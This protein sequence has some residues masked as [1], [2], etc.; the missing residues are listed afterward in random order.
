MSLDNDSRIIGVQLGE[1]FIRVFN[2]P[3]EIDLRIS[4]MVMEV[5]QQEYQIMVER[6]I[7]ES[8][9]VLVV[10]WGAE[11]QSHPELK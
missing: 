3:R 8:T 7:E 6:P 2:I 1:L 5:I 9:P 4:R 10:I 11:R